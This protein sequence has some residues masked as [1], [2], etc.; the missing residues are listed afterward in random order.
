[1]SAATLRSDPTPQRAA[2]SRAP[3]RDGDLQRAAGAARVGLRPGPRGA[4]L[5][6]LEQSSPCRAL[7]PRVEGREAAEVVFVNTAG[8]IA[9]GDR[10][11][12][13][14]EATGP[15]T[16]RAT[17][18]AAEK[19]YRALDRPAR[20]ETRLVASQ[21]ALLEWLPQETIAFDG[22]RLD[23][24]TELALSGGARAT[25]LEWLVLGRAGH[26]E[27]LRRA[28]LRDS[29]RVRRDGRLLWADGL[30]LEGAVGALAGRRALLGGAGALAT[31]IHVAESGLEPLVEALRERL[32]GSAGVTA[33]EVTVGV[34]ALP[35]L[36]LCRL[37]A[38]E[39]APLRAAVAEALAAL[40]AGVPGAAPGLPRVWST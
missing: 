1:M 28:S 4:A 5:A 30:R 35:G 31:L 10:L 16:A 37:L 17:S 2:D 32:Y 21:G 23:R 36:L 9:G 22:A 15:I 29:W 7:L 20:V 26:G 14:F 25:A 6:V 11:A 27:T 34:G 40:R 13:G 39:A 38:R 33:G 8:G 12:W 3:S 18:Q 19:L 24:R